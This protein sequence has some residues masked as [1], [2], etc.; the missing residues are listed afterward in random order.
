MGGEAPF[1]DRRYLVGRVEAARGEAT[2]DDLRGAAREAAERGET[3]DAFDLLAEALTRAAELDGKLAV[4]ADLLA[5]EPPPG[6]PVS[7]PEVVITRRLVDGEK[8]RW[9]RDRASDLL[10]IG[11]RQ[12]IPE[13]GL[14]QGG[15]VSPNRR[16]RAKRIKYPP[17]KTVEN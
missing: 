6:P 15:R 14:L 5:L 7:G 1:A 16:V 13:Q 2:V 11:V 12:A 4:T 3:A 9:L 8:L 10:K 17:D